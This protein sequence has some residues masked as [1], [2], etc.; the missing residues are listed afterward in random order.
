MFLVLEGTGTLRFGE[1]EY[2]IKKHDIIACPPGGRDVAH[3]IVNTGQAELKYLSLSTNEPYDIC[4][5]PDSNKIMSIVGKTGNRDFKHISKAEH[6]VDY[7]E[8]EM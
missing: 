6:E 8:G 3:Q 4:E 7:Y 1:K 5:Y 2:P